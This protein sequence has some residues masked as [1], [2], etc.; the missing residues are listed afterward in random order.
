VI[1]PHGT[2]I[3]AIA[4]QHEGTLVANPTDAFSGVDGLRVKDGT[5]GCRQKRA[6][7]R[8]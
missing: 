1:G 6:S 8:D 7:R 2:P 5:L 4:L 3:V